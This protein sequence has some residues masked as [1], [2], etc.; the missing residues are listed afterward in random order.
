MKKVY[1]TLLVNF[2]WIFT[3]CKNDATSPEEPVEDL[4]NIF[5]QNGTVTIKGT[6]DLP[7]GTGPYPVIIPIHGSG[8]RTRED[9][10]FAVQMFQSE[11]FAVFRY[12][13]RGVGQ[14]TGTYEPVSA[15]NSERVFND[16]SSDILAIVRYLKQ[17]DDIDATRIGLA[18]SSQGGWIAPLAASKSSDIKF[19]ISI[20]GAASSVGISDYFDSLTD[21]GISIEEAGSSLGGF[22]GE[23]GFDPRLAI[24]S[25][26]IPGLWVYGGMDDS[27]PTDAD[28]NVLNEIINQTGKDFTISLFPF[29]D[30]DLIDTRTGQLGTEAVLAI[31]SWLRNK[32]K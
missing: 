4:K 10:Q 32:V 12:D 25:L 29:Y 2:I 28:I 13:K 30:H 1:L 11:G 26:N 15:E 6:L 9:A 23:H 14:S 24:S 16:L 27:N 22:T 5:V 19:I 20:S 17:R 3:F 8:E 7:A 31:I 18:G 21:Q